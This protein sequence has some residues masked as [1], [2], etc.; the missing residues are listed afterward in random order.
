MNNRTERTEKV[1]MDEWSR[2]T[3]KECTTEQRGLKKGTCM[4]GTGGK[5]R[6]DNRTERKETLNRTK[7]KVSAGFTEEL[8]TSIP[9]AS[10]SENV[11]LLQRGGRGQG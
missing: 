8:C 2:A 10:D 1:N 4:N 9:G 11:N 6:M 5:G 7:H 3:G